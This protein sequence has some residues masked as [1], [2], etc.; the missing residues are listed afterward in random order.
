MI[1]KIGWEVRDVSGDPQRG[2]GLVGGSSVRCG[3]GRG[4]PGRVWGHSEKSGT[5]RG[6]LGQVQD[7][8]GTIA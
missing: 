5:D 7:G 4:G 1:C 6:T 8:S 2:P 3:T